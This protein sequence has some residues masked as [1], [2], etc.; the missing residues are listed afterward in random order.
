[1]KT[2]PPYPVILIRSTGTYG[3]VGQ[4]A[5]RRVIDLQVA[6]NGLDVAVYGAVTAHSN[7]QTQGNVTIDGRGHDV[8]GNLCSDVGSSL[9]LRH[10]LPGRDGP[11]HQR[12]PQR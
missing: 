3:S 1:M 9:L 6:R 4:G 11:L 8:D 12:G 2:N 10:R 7:I 5:G